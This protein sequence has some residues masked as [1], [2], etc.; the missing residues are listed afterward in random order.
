MGVSDSPERKAADE[1]VAILCGPTED[2][3]GQRLI[4]LRQGELQA[5]EVRPARQGMPLFG[6]EL[7]RLKPRE[8]TPRICDVDVVHPAEAP[9]QDRVGPAQVATDR[10]RDNWERIFGSGA[11]S[12][13]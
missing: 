5:G 1:D 2:Q 3:Q 7:L 6:R 8:N 4:R 10:Y 11:L 13:N 9:L 12:A